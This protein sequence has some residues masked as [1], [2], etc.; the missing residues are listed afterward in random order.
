M[1]ATVADLRLQVVSLFDYVVDTAFE[2]VAGVTL[3][4]VGDTFKSAI[5]GGLPL[6]SALEAQVLAKLDALSPSAGAAAIAA[7]LDGLDGVEASVAGG[8]VDIHI[9]AADSYTSGTEKFDLAFGLPALG[10]KVAGSAGLTLGAAVDLNLAFDTAT[11]TLTNLGGA[12]D[13]LKLTID[14]SL[15]GFDGSGK[16]G[17]LGVNITDKQATPEIALAASLDIA[18]GKT[19]PALT[20][21]DLTTTLSGDASLRLGLETSLDAAILPKLFTDLVVDYP[22]VGGVLSVP[23]ISLQDIELDLGSFVDFLGGVF[24]PVIKDVFGSFPLQDLLDAVTTPLPIIDDAV[25]ALRL[26]PLF[27]RVG[28]DGIINL[29]DLAAFEG[30]DPATLNAFALAF[31]FIKGITE[32]SGAGELDRVKL[33]SVTLTGAAPLA[34]G[35]KTAL[36]EPAAAIFDPPP[37]DPLAG[38]IAGLGDTLGGTPT[39]KPGLGGILQPLV[40]VLS[41]AGISIPLLSNPESIIP[42]LLNGLD[43]SGAGAVTLIQ[44]SVPE[45]RPPSLHYD[46]FFPI[47]GPIGITL[48]GNFETRIKVDFGYDTKG[49]ADGS[50]E[51]GFYFTTAKLAVPIPVGGEIALFEPS[52]TV[53]AGIAALAAVNVGVA[54]VGIGGGINAGLAAYFPH[55]EADGKLRLADV[56]SGCLFDPITGEFTAEVFARIKVGFGPFSFTRRFDIADV[57]LAEFNFG[58]PPPSTDPLH[59]LATLGPEGGVAAHTLA[60]NIGDRA[61]VRSING[62]AGIDN[63]ES[64]QVR[65]AYTAKG[66]AIPGAL[67][68]SAFGLAEQYGNAAAA[69]DLIVA[70]GHDQRDTIVVAADV[71]Q[72]A[73]LNGGTGDDLLVGGAGNDIINGQADG[74]RLIGGAGN[75]Q[76]FGE[77]GDDVLEGGAGAD[78]IDGGNGFDQV[79]YENSPVAVKFHY[80]EVAGRNAFVGEGGEAS[81]D[82]LYN[83][84]YLIGSHFDDVFFGNPGQSNTIEGLAGNDVLVGGSADDFL[85]G[86][87][88]ADTLTGGG[89]DHDATS[90]VTSAGQVSVDLNTGVGHYGDAEGDILSSIENV[91]GSFADDVLIGDGKANVLDG[92]FGNDH[93]VGGGGADTLSGGEGADIIE[94]GG[95]G[96]TIDG[97]GAITNP[98][99]DLLTYRNH[100][101]GVNINLLDGSGDDAVTRATFVTGELLAGYSSIENLE[102]S[103]AGDQLTGDDQYNII[104]GLAGDDVI[105]GSGGND[106]ITGGDGGD[107][108]DGGTG[109]D[110]ADYRESPGAVNVDLGIGRGFYNDAAG[111]TL[112]NIEDLRGSDYADTLIGNGVS[113]RIDPGL[114]RPFGFSDYVLGGIAAGDRDTLVLDYSRGDSGKGATGGFDAFSYDAGSFTRQQALSASQLDGVVFSQIE[115]LEF[116]G[117]QRDD[118][119]FGGGYGDL[120]ATGLGNDLVY[121]GLG[122]DRIFTGNGDD[123]VVEG[124]GADRLFSPLGG[125]QQVQLDGGRGIDYLSIS[126]A[127]YD[128]NV[129]LAGT[130]GSAEFNGVNAVLPLNGSAISNFELLY[131]VTTGGGDDR[132]SQ[133]GVRP[134]IFVGGFGVDEFRPGLGADYVDGG[135]EFRVGSEITDIRY[136]SDGQ[137]SQLVADGPL[138][139]LRNDGDLLVLDY[140]AGSVP[141]NSTVNVVQLGV[142]LLIVEFQSYSLSTNAGFYISGDNV[143]NFTSIERVAIQGSSVDDTLIGTDLLFGRNDYVGGVIPASESKRGDDVLTGND[144]NDFIIGRTGDDRI[145]GGNGD[146]IIVGSTLRLSESDISADDGEV[147]TMTGGAGDDLFVFGVYARGQE[148]VYYKD[149]GGEGG[150]YPYQSD[151]NRGIV[152][153]FGVGGDRLLLAGTPEEYRTEESGGSTFIYLRDGITFSGLPNPAADELIGELQGVTGFDLRA[154]NVLYFGPGGIAPASVGVSANG[155]GTAKAI[156]LLDPQ[157]ERVIAAAEDSFA[158]PRAIAA[159]PLAK[160][161]E[162]PLAASPAAAPL[163]SPSWVT[164]TNDPD[165]LKAALFGGAGS[166]LGGGT[167]TTDGDAAAFGTFDGDPFGLGKGIVLSTGNVADLAGPNLVDGGLS[168]GETINLKFVEVGAFNGSTIYRADLSNLG[169]DLNSLRLGDN[170]AGFGGSGGSASGFDIDAVALSRTRLDSVGA[171]TDLNDPATLPRLDVFDF[172]AARVAYSPGTQRPETSSAFPNASDSQGAINGLP[173]FAYA[174]LDKFDFATA[175]R[176]YVS[177]GDGGS[178]GFDLNATVPA[179]GPLYLYVAEAGNNGEKLT[180]G[181]TASVNR[182]NTPADLSTDLGLPGVAGDTVSLEYRFTPTDASTQA[183]FDFVFFSEELVEYAQS[184][185]NDS[186][187]ITLN[188]V[189]LARLSDGSFAS[190]NTL[191]TP[192][193]GGDATSSIYALRTDSPATDFIYNPAGTGPAAGETRADGYSKVLHFTGPLIVGAENVLRIEAADVRDGLLDSGILIRGGSLGGSILDG[194]TLERD[195]SPL[196]EGGHRDIHFGITVPAGGTP[197]SGPVTVVFHPSAGLDLGSGAGVDVARVLPAGTLAGTIGATAVFDGINDPNRQEVVGV[198]VTGIAGLGAVAP[199]LIDVDEAVRAL[200]RTIGDAPVR[201]DRAHPDA[202]AKA[203]TADGIAITHTAHH[204]LLAPVYTPVDFGT[205]NPGVLAGS[206]MLAG[207]LGVSGVSGGPAGPPQQIAGDEALR[208]SFRSGDLTDLSIDFAR[209]ESGDT[210]RIELFDRAGLLLRT[211]NATTPTFALSGLGGVGA[212]VVSASTGAFLIDSLTSSENV[213][214]SMARSF[215]PQFDS[216]MP[217][218][219]IHNSR[220]DGGHAM[221]QVV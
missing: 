72:D 201:F 126:L 218:F 67:A 103:Q 84:E 7:A 56:G 78:S 27:D 69:A 100:A 205:R 89:G 130:D 46:E 48:V 32:A 207:D 178:L 25:H 183:E 37:G 59:G 117:T 28:H 12:A 109:I 157:L 179:G 164:Q 13:E 146:D 34:A 196:A 43:P 9:G 61:G 197:P 174:T 147:D 58:C 158:A 92:W 76:L 51:D 202:W 180:S 176:G 106:S 62:I 105:A 64:F 141:V 145:D 115:R 214:A 181:F 184:A 42:L 195:P 21:A 119:V 107:T 155:F 170:S 99:P 108:L 114:S 199:L 153:D 156:T 166:P 33:G 177:L 123:V 171:L 5:L 94:G 182:L 142:E 121:G 80:A 187:K 136:N 120:I 6:F 194:F 154:P 68:V 47:I 148:R 87:A 172:N 104:R 161:F 45:L 169:V 30:A 74:D 127:A 168:L 17:F 110:L 213:E 220:F 90:Y 16:L 133:P 144:G 188:G 39:Q 173:D 165:T 55:A 91:Q 132:L 93:I 186:F 50:F 198:D 63:G 211:E 60:L 40:N 152:T 44:Y 219:M 128:G 2:S 57:T 66:V 215:V 10:F 14:G 41:S 1:A 111:D 217:E 75:D 135:Y 88:G 140:S 8:N 112:V 81:G 160:P 216:L 113:N 101:G 65:N 193:A 4:F 71:R 19:I 102:G 70:D 26:T 167:L 29:L 190:V 11:G 35:L 150:G 206:D 38:A 162:L 137:I 36:A 86:G 97:G 221:L 129:V 203:W 31:S 52:A 77:D 96:D 22:V 85:L 83:V 118:A 79:T 192:A 208:F 23:A 53:D 20:L 149:D 143:V 95:D 138:P 82:L 185:F 151:P 134:N 18:D 15:D 49:I 139:V 212:V 124:T 159:D 163:V 24:G 73:H 204:S 54:E 3:P 125:S 210:A 200:T 98:G 175:G 191:Y 122:A 116:N 131:A 189:N 209:F